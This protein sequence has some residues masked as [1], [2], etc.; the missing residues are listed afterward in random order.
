MSI[1]ITNRT[2]KQYNPNINLSKFEPL[3]PSRSG[4]IGLLIFKISKEAV[5]QPCL[6]QKYSVYAQNTHTSCAYFGIK[7]SGL[8]PIYPNVTL[9][10]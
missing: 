1:Y 7:F 8:S 2:Y 3:K 4:D 10:S 6:D 5:K 9:R